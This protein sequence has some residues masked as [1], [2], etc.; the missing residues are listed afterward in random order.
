MCSNADIKTCVHRPWLAINITAKLHKCAPR[1]ISYVWRYRSTQKIIIIAICVT[2]IG[3]SPPNNGKLR[4]P[5]TCIGTSVL[6]YWFWFW[7][8][9][10]GTLCLFSK[11]RILFI[12]KSCTKMAKTP[13]CMM[14]ST[15]YALNLI[16]LV[17]GK[18]NY[19]YIF[20]H[21]SN[22]WMTQVVDILSCWRQKT[23]LF[24]QFNAISYRSIN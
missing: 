24:Y 9:S 16:G 4:W 21:L 11:L 6:M 20:R 12:T 19:K 13:V 14:M 17:G 7:I 15:F 3:I 10:P 8:F 22:S 18:R 1:H 2:F 5:L 23:R